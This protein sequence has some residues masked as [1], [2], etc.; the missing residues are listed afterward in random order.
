[1][2]GLSAAQKSLGLA[3]VC[4]KYATNTYV[5]PMFSCEACLGYSVLNAFSFLTR[6]IDLKGRVNREGMGSILHPL[7]RFKGLQ[8]P[9]LDQAEARNFIL[10][11]GCEG[12]STWAALC[13][14]S[15]RLSRAPNGEVGRLG[16]E[17]QGADIEGSSFICGTIIAVP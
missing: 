17:I 13:C 11:S 9:E 15:R 8:P 5:A 3:Q 12:C 6:L 16:I 4:R 10:P 1:M 14:S 2:L 7:A